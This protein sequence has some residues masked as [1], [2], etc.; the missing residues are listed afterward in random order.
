MQGK[1]QACQTEVDNSVEHLLIDRE[2]KKKGLVQLP[3]ILQD[4]MLE[5]GALQKE[6]QEL[7]SQKSTT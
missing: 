5:I 6:L 1:C 7:K 3:N 4:L 2:L